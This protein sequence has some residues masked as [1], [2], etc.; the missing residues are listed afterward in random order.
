MRWRTISWAGVAL[1]CLSACA[2]AGP[3]K[4]KE[5]DVILVGDSTVSSITGW[6]DAF[7][8]SMTAKV[9]S[10]TNLARAG[11]SSRS[12]RKEGSWKGVLQKIRDGGPSNALVLI[13]FGHNDAGRD[14][15]RR[16]DPDAD[17]TDI[18]SQYVDDARNSGA[19]PVLITP[20][21][22]RI[23]VDGKIKDGLEPYANAVRRIA[24]ARDARLIDLHAMSAAAL[25]KMSPEEARRLGPDGDQPD[26]NHLGPRGA[27]YFAD[28]VIHQ[29]RL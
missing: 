3:S 4:P 21:A 26:I 19:E 7:C 20:V 29:L 25:E 15:K 16:T 17:F 10:C 22:R 9:K 12:Y 27:R 24:A 5:R 1:V 14:E 23:Y 18:I 6:G 11:R 8:Q 13:Q 28:M 2:Q